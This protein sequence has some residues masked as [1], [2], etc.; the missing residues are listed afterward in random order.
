[1]ETHQRKETKLK[2]AIPLHAQMQQL[3]RHYF[4]C[5]LLTTDKRLSKVN[6]KEKRRFV[7]KRLFSLF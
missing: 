1:M 7:E 4:V 3:P 2:K 6:E 5:S